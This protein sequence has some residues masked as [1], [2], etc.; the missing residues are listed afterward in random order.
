LDSFKAFLQDNLNQILALI[1]VTSRPRDLTRAQLKELR[2][3][4][5]AAG[6]S[7]TKLQAAWRETTNEDIAASII[8]F[9]RQA[10]LG[11]ALVSY[12]QRVDRAL[13]KILASRAWTPPQR[14]WLE[15]IAKQLKVET[16]M[17]REA[18]DRG[19]FK[20]QGGGFTRIDKIFDGQLGEILTQINANLWQDAV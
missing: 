13:A 19:E 3:L 7:E 20:T 16:I 12:E 4:L 9:I 10:A 15:W 18:L 6:Y 2:L 17:D 11:D 1:V 8:G 5:D 14:K